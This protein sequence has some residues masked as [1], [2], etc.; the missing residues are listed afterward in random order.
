MPERAIVHLSMSDS[1]TADA[2]VSQTVRTAPVVEG[3]QPTKGRTLSV[4]GGVVIFQPRGTTYELHLAEPEG[5]W[6]G[7]VGKPTSGVLRVKARKVY[8]VPSGGSFVVPI[9]GTPR[10]VQGRVTDVLEGGV[11]RRIVLQAGATV[12][13]D[14]PAD[15][16]AIDLGEGEIGQGSL[17]NVVC[18]PDAWIESV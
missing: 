13:V 3:F 9:M 6:P 12:V 11:N 4:K 1:T 8:S 14:L 18:E 10:I 5:G 17:V 7:V 15:D 16:H 2:L